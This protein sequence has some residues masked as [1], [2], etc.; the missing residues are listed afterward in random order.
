[1]ATH[2]ERSDEFCTL[3]PEKNEVIGEMGKVDLIRNKNLTCEFSR[4]FA[5]QKAADPRR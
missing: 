2:R 4:H 3:V 1:M 5:S